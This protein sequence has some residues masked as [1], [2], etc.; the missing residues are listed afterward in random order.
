MEN[1]N[2]QT[3]RIMWLQQ[4]GAPVHYHRVVRQFLNEACPNRWIGRRG[5]INWPAGS[6]DL[7]PIDFFLRGFVKKKVYI[8]TT[9]E[10]MKLR[11]RNA[12]PFNKCRYAN[13][14]L[15]IIQKKAECLY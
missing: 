4:D 2:L 6:A 10:D 14:C 7:A 15:T 8:P 9:A 12:F 11:I 5:A 3:R 13:A 1:V